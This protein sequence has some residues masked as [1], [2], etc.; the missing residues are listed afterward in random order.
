MYYHCSPITGLKVIKP[1]KP[2]LFRKRSGVYLTTLLPMAL[3]YAVCNY[4]YTYGFTKDGQIYFE[5]YFP[6]ALEI[7]Y[8]GKCASL[9]L[10]N[11]TAT[12]TTPIPNEAV[13][14][15]TVP[16]MREIPIPDACEAILA[17]ER[18][19]NL[20]IRRFHEL[21]EETI[22]WIRKAEADTIR[23]FDLHHLSGP[24]ADY[25]REHYPD[26]WAMTEKEM[27]RET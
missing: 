12:E 18:L 27:D 3:M 23:K 1:G 7:L 6:D 17:Q 11:P 14:G 22:N 8:R 5:E 20:V 26:S 19:G 9:Y 13:S 16:V 24:M 10:C 2:K 4:E 21:P 25:Y 15:V